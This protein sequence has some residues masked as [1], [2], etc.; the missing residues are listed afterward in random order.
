MSY[1][2]SKS[3]RDRI[4]HNGLKKTFLLLYNILEKLSKIGYR[5]KI[6]IATKLKTYF[7]FYVS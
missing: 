6:I 3:R 4:T 7:K 1:F 2:P 5:D